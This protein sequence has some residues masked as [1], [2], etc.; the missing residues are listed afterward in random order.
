MKK[1]DLA[2]SARLA[3]LRS[4]LPTN[5]QL[6]LDGIARR[7]LSA[8]FNLPATGEQVSHFLLEKAESGLKIS[9][10]RN[11]CSMIIKWHRM[12]SYSDAVADIAHMARP[13]IKGLMRERIESGH[14]ESRDSATPLL[15][16]DALKIDAYLSNRLATADSK[17]AGIAAQDLALFR[18]LFWSGGR[19]SEIVSL[20]FWQVRFIDDPRSI[21]FSWSLTK[22]SQSGLGSSRLI[23][24]LPAADPVG[25]MSDWLELYWPFGNDDDRDNKF[26]FVRKDQ[27]GGWRD[28]SMHPNSV[29][30]WLRKK[31]RL[32]GVTYWKD[33]S[34]HSARHGLSM[35][36]SDSLN[37]REVLDYFKWKRPE[38]AIGYI[39]NK[40][41]SNAVFSVLSKASTISKDRHL[42][43]E[44]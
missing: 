26:V 44:S 30:G 10:L 32:A 8:G 21:E 14:H 17:E 9:T 22:T 13:V 33:L 15:L 3:S 42:K 2:T 38:T 37:L 43:N 5:T 6:S 11:Y 23:P 7:L 27:R 28:K 29:P 36:M 4:K 12:A 1:T 20:K 35:L 34:G 31:A 40:G 41:V 19:E 25:A 16:E 39:T 18:A 24:G